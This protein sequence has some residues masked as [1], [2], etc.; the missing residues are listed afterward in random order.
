MDIFG[1][2]GFAESDIF[3]VFYEE[4]SAVHQ[5]VGVRFAGRGNMGKAFLQVFLLTKGHVPA[6]IPGKDGQFLRMFERLKA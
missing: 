2:I 4:N 6:V 5:P 3:S 1:R